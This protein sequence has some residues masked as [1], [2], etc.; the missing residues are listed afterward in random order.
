[1]SRAKQRVLPS[2]TMLLTLFSYNEYSGRLRRRGKKCGR[3]VSI[4]GIDYWSSR[5]AW[6]MVTGRE[7]VDV[8]VARDG[9]ES[10]LRFTNL[11]ELTYSQL[12][13]RGVA[14][15][16]SKTGQRGVQR[17]A[18]GKYKAQIWYQ[19]KKYHCGTFS[20][21]TAAAKARKQMRMRLVRGE[22]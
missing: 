19:N 11:V 6:K 13:T 15:S 3:K 22:V 16:T 2:Q 17:T 20:T 10:N 18:S 4:C 5:I 8:I 12:R 9:D 21:V 7:P 1:M 14:H